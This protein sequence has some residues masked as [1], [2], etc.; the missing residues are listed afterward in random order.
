MLAVFGDLALVRGDSRDELLEVRLDEAGLV[1]SDQRA[2]VDALGKLVG[3]RLNLMRGELATIPV[4]AT[5][6][7]CWWETKAKTSGT[8]F[9]NKWGQVALFNG[10]AWLASAVHRSGAGLGRRGPR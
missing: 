1:E 5:S 6:P 7:Q 2:P 10:C 8:S 9:K 4:W 3:G